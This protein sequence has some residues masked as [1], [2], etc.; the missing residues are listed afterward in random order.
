MTLRIVLDAD[1]GVDDAH[2]IMMALTH[3][4]AEVVAITTVAGNVSLERTTANALVILDVVE[5]DIPVYPG[6]K[7]AL[8]YPT[9]CRATSHGEDGLGKC[10]YPPANR[11]AEAE[12][13]VQA[14]IRL[15]N[16]A[17]GELTL[18]TL[19]PLTNLAVAIRLDPDL[20]QKYKDLVVLGGAIQANGNSWVPA[21]EF[22]FFIDPEAAAVVFEAWP[23]ITLVPWE[24]AMKHALTR[25]QFDELTAIDS[26]RADFF[27][28]IFAD[29]AA[30]QFIE[31]GV[32]YDPDPLAV[33]VALE[34]EIVR[35]AE[36]HYVTIELAGSLTRGQSVVDWL[37]ITGKE[38]NAH[39]VEAIDEERFFE[40]LKLSL[41]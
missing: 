24:T 21:A 13:A 9:L 5:K 22:N 4:Q 7:D 29:R 30:Q 14:L 41:Q 33:A 3:P 27:G 38:P 35:Q 16:E 8:V 11:H 6:C 15:A 18:V 32:C 37:G 1:P 26:P 23:Q 20:P 36:H 25:Q 19:G 17:P 39:L 2:A 12:P 40:L 28:R 34:P 10:N 31:L